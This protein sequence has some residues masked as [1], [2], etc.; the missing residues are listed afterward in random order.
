MKMKGALNL[1]EEVD[2]AL[3]HIGGVDILRMSLP[4]KEDLVREAELH[5]ALSDP[6]R[7][8][9]LHALASAELCPCVLKEITGLADSKLSYHLSKLETTGLIHHRQSKNWKVFSLTLSGKAQVVR[10]AARKMDR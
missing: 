9:I 5:T 3:C 10:M 6:F 2:E 8:Q 7:L 1:P 4:S